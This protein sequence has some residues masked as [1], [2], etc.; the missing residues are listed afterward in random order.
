ML[1]ENERLRASDKITGCTGGD[2]P[3]C[4]NGCDQVKRV[5]WSN[6][7]DK[8]GLAFSA[9]SVENNIL[10]CRERISTE[11]RAAR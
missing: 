6:T 7:D 5:S 10:K 4:T 3:G 11:P 8:V 2:A 1:V 9:T